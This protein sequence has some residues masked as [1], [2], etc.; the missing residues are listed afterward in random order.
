[1]LFRP[2]A[3]LLLASL[4]WL[5][6]TPAQ[7]HFLWLWQTKSTSGTPVVQAHFSEAGDDPEP[8]LLKRLEGLQVWHRPAAGEIQSLT[9]KSSPE[10]IEVTLPAKLDAEHP[11]VLVTEKNFGVS[12]RGDVKFLLQYYAKLYPGSL[13]DAAK[14][15]PTERLRL[16]IVPVIEG[17][18]LT[19]NVTW[20]G[21]PVADSEVVVKGAGLKGDKVKTDAK[22]QVS[23]DLGE[24]GLVEL[25]ARHIE[26]KAGKL[27]DKEY[28]E[29]RNYCT[30]TFPWAGADK[31]TASVTA[32]AKSELPLL[33]EGLTSFGAAVQGDWLYVYGGHLAKPHQYSMETQ[34]PKLR[35]VN[36]TTPTAWE[37]LASG[38][39]LQGVAMVACGNRL[40]R[41]GGFSA[42]NAIGEKQNLWSV[43]EVA[44]YDPAEN[45]WSNLPPLP[46]PRSSHDAAVIGNTIYVAG[47]WQLRGAD[48][49]P[50]WHN[51]AWSLD[52]S[53][54]TPA[55][56]QLTTP[57]FER[58]A[59]AVAALADKL[60]VIGG[61][62]SDNGM[63]TE[64]AVYD[65][66][67]R[68][69]SAAPE[70]PGKEMEGFGAS[71]F[72]VGNRLCVS[73]RNGQ[74]LSLQA[75]ADKWETLGNL[76]H[77]RFF[78]RLLAGIHQDV[79]V[80]GG[81]AADKVKELEVVAVA[82]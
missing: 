62:A 26:N 38:P 48:A 44:A 5:S 55:W 78:H 74:L 70:L 69:W 32:P 28:T 4:I 75:G 34:S 66:A 67:S 7:A 50:V 56:Q 39:R 27:E 6:A 64:V 61:M 33:P 71:A 79:I 59:V 57:P 11:G 9:V 46:A 29:V 17:K 23:F 14:L 58:R 40:V 43:S 47:G 22:G 24:A 82:K 77:P 45:L 37:D 36:L 18:K 8:E 13:A 25:R 42:H 76:K 60:Y 3:A 30:V 19:L 1:M 35:R 20:E 10:N 31:T 63:T 81:S 41:I 80:I 53:A 16:D 54:A 68:T 12:G 21:K 15:G 65:P 49:D 52:L 73:T 2:V 72:A 51:T